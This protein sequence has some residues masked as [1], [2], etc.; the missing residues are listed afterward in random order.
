MSE[1]YAQLLRT[2]TSWQ[3]ELNK[4]VSGNIKM[5]DSPEALT[6]TLSVLGIALVYGIVHALGPGHGKALV[7][8]YFLKEGGSYRNALKM[9][10][11]IAVIHALS[12]LGLTLVV[13]YLI[14]AVFSRTFRE[15]GGYS[16]SVSA[17]LIILVGCYLVYEA[18]RERRQ[19]EH[20]RTRSGKSAMAVAFSAGMVPCPGVMT[21]T[22]FAMSMG[23]L[24]LGVASA[25]VMSLG[26]GLTISLA[27]IAT[28]GLRRRGV[29]LLGAHGHWLQIASAVM[30][31]LLGSVLLAAN[32]ESGA[33]KPF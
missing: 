25:V 16:M 14:D 8:L 7:G 31:I 2:I 10:Y 13:Y 23:H 29:P 28:V 15:F 18:W 19:E 17:G 30:I 12:A 32:L 26:M 1:Y 6:A 27:G 21:I 22:L 3:Y 24:A 11:A 5:L 9:G 20:A 33:S 4:L